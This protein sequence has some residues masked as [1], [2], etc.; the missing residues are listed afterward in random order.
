MAE[1]TPGLDPSN[2]NF[3]GADPADTQAYQD[4]LKA[5]VTALEQ[6]YA[7]PN[8]FNV[9]AGF[10]KP[11]LGGFGASLGSASQA[12]GENIEKQRESALPL[13]QM[14]A[15][16][17]A[18]KIA[19]GQKKTVADML[20]DRKPG[21]PLT[22]E[23]VR[24]VTAIAPGSSVALSLKDELAA[25]QAQ[26]QNRN[27]EQTALVARVRAGVAAGELSLDE[28]QEMLKKGAPIPDALK[29]AAPADTKAPN[30]PAALSSTPAE[31][32]PGAVPIGKPDIK[33]TDLPAMGSTLNA[34]VAASVVPTP[35][36]KEPVIITSPLGPQARIPEAVRNTQAAAREEV[37]NKKMEELYASGGSPASYEPATRILEDQT[38]LIKKN[39]EIARKVM[40]IM[41]QGTFRSQIEALLQSGIGL[42][43][44]GLAGNIHIDVA[45]AKKAGLGQT[46]REVADA[47]AANFAAL[48]IMKQRAGNLSPN[49]ARNAEIGLYNELTPSMNTTPQA[50]LKAIAHMKNDLD[51]THAQYKFARSVYDDANPDVKVGAGVPNRMDAILNHPSFSD[52]YKPYSEKN[53]QVSEAYQ[54]YLNASK[55]KKR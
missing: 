44:Q 52:I 41:A 30:V 43:F 15:Q 16:L 55:A 46:D 31:A 8:W 40:S 4:A 21:D 34:P 6:R 11:Q 50:A 1:K 49:S 22:P 26:T 54:E 2:I 38:N 42:N 35:E 18:S 9:A 23:F 27:A 48:A 47:L 36:K 53:R 12:L 28:A 5:S 14:R 24:E 37:A 51:A 20:A 17:A 3:Y 19:M 13:A 25:Q 39:P 45:A 29:P 10:L 33:T 7:Q 32:A